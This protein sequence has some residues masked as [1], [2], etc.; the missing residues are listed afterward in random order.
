M[1]R[2]KNFHNI[3]QVVKKKIAVYMCTAYN[4]FYIIFIVPKLYECI[5]LYIHDYV[6]MVIK[7]Y[8]YITQKRLSDTKLKKVFFFA[9]S[10]YVTF[11]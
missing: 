9:R 4:H 5:H 1:R 11:E 7:A 3:K 8:K 6:H 10:M 2:K